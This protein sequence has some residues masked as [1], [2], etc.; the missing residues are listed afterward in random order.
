MYEQY[1]GLSRTPFRL[2]SEPDMFYAGEN[3]TRILKSISDALKSDAGVITLSG[4]PGT[5]KTTV[6]RR[7]VE[8]S[9]IPGTI[10]TRI[11]RGATDS[12]FNSIC[13]DLNQRLNSKNSNLEAIIQKIAIEKK[14]ILVLVDE[15]QQITKDEINTLFSIIEKTKSLSSY[16]KFLLVGHEDLNQHFNLSHISEHSDQ[17]SLHFQMLPLKESEISE[18]VEHRLKNT[19]WNGNPEFDQSVFS[20]AFN[21]T[22]GVPRRVNSFFD[23]FLLHLFMESET[24][25]DTSIMKE[26][27]K[28]LYDELENDPHPDLDS[29]DLRSALRHEKKSFE[30]ETAKTQVAE[31]T[32]TPEPPKIAPQ[33]PEKPTIILPAPPPEKEVTIVE[34]APPLTTVA[35]PKPKVIKPEIIKPEVEKKEIE[36]PAP[37]IALVKP[38][39]PATPSAAPKEVAA[40]VTIEKEKPKPRPK[41]VLTPEQEKQGQL[42]L[43]VSNYL[44]NP[45]RFKHYSD[46]FYKLPEDIGTLLILATEK[47]IN[48]EKALPNQLL[49]VIPLEIRRMIRHFLMR[50]LFTSN[51]DPFRILGLQSSASEKQINQHF[52]YLMR[53][54]RSDMGGPSEWSKNEE[55]AIKHA[56]IK[57]LGSNSKGAKQPVTLTT[58]P[59][60][61][62]I[63]RANLEATPLK[64]NSVDTSL[65]S[66]KNKNSQDNTRD[67]P[68]ITNTATSETKADAFIQVAPET[69]Q[70]ATAHRP[71]EIK[72]SNMEY[73]EIAD[74]EEHPFH[75]TKVQTKSIPWIPVAA[76][77]GIVG[78]IVIGV[79]LSGG[80]KGDASLQS[81]QQARIQKADVAELQ[82]LKQTPKVLEQ[83]AEIDSDSRISKILAQSKKDEP[84]KPK[85]P[86]KKESPQK[87]EVAKKESKP[88]K[89]AEEKTASKTTDSKKTEPK[90]VTKQEPKKQ[91]SQVAKSNAT[92]ESKKAPT[93]TKETKIAQ[94]VAPQPKKPDDSLIANLTDADLNR[95]IFYFKRSYESGDIDI[96]GSLFTEDAITNE[97]A[98]RIQIIRDYDALFE[99][100]DKRSIQL[101]NLTWSKEGDIA[102]GSGTFIL[103]IIE[104]EGMAPEEI[105]GEINIKA[106]KIDHKAQIRELFYR[107]S[108]AAN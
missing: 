45:E 68:L 29:N 85:E 98:N 69:K 28:E 93:P 91:P 35:K 49:N 103:S 71:L 84:P 77:F 18:Y 86:P 42:I 50:V 64:T 96:F 7:A 87:Q 16:Y 43:M 38:S 1:F 83:V 54:C 101:K 4:L 89:K 94:K 106:E 100:T 78:A 60:E 75:L 76:G 21:I 70:P 36:P 108:F 80:E 63:A 20:T 92:N 5:G 58:I 33:Q 95:L 46:E 55:N 13:G 26:F 44:E 23:R 40:T 79:L 61:K 57:I 51:S 22:K 25:A 104:K 74:T 37:K 30:T 34:E 27:C 66:T 90:K 107:Y 102:N 88:A 62:S 105:R 39:K 2:E 67:I 12:L 10:V 41:R 9:I 99:V 19:N 6:I 81:V 8:A 73:E 15:A 65:R 82:L 97:S 72:G 48:I 31:K 56:Y 52:D 11:N 32:Q 17:L 3:Q 14:H 24:R 59:N 47:D 53:I